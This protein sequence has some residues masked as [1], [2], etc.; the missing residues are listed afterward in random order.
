[1]RNA[2]RMVSARSLREENVAL[3]RSEALANASCPANETSLAPLA[4]PA[5]RCGVAATRAC[6][7]G[8][9]GVRLQ[10]LPSAT[11]LCAQQPQGAMIVQCEQFTDRNQRQEVA[12]HAR[13]KR[14]KRPDSSALPKCGFTCDGTARRHPLTR[15]TQRRAT[16]SSPRRPPGAGR[17]GSATLPWPWLP[18]RAR[19]WRAVACPARSPWRASA[20]HSCRA[21]KAPWT[22]HAAASR[23]CV[24]PGCEDRLGPS[25][26][27]GTGQEA[28]RLQFGSGETETRCPDGRWLV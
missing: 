7:W 23:H 26:G 17:G 8:W 28:R 19:F 1:M 2:E 6:A 27:E 24:C 12:T 11:S 14:V 4:L 9:T 15:R 22:F 16:T 10:P 5:R 20:R 25:C 3:T 18:S 13:S 21:G